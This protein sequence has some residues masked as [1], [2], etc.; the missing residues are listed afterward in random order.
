MSEEQIT[1]KAELLAAMEESWPALQAALGRLSDVQMTSIF[2]AEGWTVKDHVLHLAAWERS[3]VHFLQGQPRHTALGIDETL[4]LQG[5]VDTINAVMQQQSQARSVAEALQELQAVHQQL[6]QLLAPL[7]DA[8]LQLR[9]RAYL[10][11]EPGAGDGPLAIELIAG[12]SAEHFQEH[13]EWI[14]SVASNNG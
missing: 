5:P 11:D 1:T 12:N 8:E 6:L 14:E 3:V 10:P 9:Y 7:S 13:L 4:Y 2:D